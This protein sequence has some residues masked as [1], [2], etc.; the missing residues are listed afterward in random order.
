MILKG[1][2]RHE[3]V[4]LKNTGTWLGVSGGQIFYIRISWTFINCSDRSN[5]HPDRRTTD[6]CAVTSCYGQNLLT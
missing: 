6:L 3:L 5:I 1:M 4:V 2:R